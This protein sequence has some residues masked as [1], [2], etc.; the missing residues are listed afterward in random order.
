[1]LEG[2]VDNEFLSASVCSFI[3]LNTVFWT[4]LSEVW[5]GV[6]SLEVGMGF[7]SACVLPT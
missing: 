1:M 5:W 4:N 2:F 6:V 3:N 7:I